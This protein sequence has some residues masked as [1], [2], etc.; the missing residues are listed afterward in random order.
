M[1]TWT[2]QRS[3]D[4]WAY[5]TKWWHHGNKLHIL[6]PQLCIQISR[7]SCPPSILTPRKQGTHP[8]PASVPPDFQRVVSCQNANTTEIVHTPQSHRCIFKFPGSP[9]FQKCVHHRNR[10]HISVLQ[11]SIQ[12]SRES[13]YPKMLTLRNYGTHL[14]PAD[15]YPDFQRVLSSQNADTTEIRH[16]SQ[17]RRCLSRFSESPVFPKCWH[18]KNRAHISVPQVSIQIS[19]KSCLPKM[20]TQRKYGI[21]LSPA[22]VHPDF[23]RILSS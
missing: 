16:T 19:R 14:S 7:G 10:A 18:H 5:F 8:S 2:C 9:V 23:Q 22:G 3:I 17:S 1:F 20:L 4:T 21:Y 11:V 6:V 13:C 12:I 15:V